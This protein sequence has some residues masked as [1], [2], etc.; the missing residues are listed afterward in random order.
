MT[1]AVANIDKNDFAAMAALMGVATPA[2]GKKS[3]LAR[4]RLNHKAIMGTAEIKGKTKK[5]E[6]VPA[7]T[8]RIDLDDGSQLYAESA[9]FRP[10]MSRFMHKRFVKGMGDKPNKFIKTLMGTNINVDL[11]DTEGTSNCGRPSGFIKDW[12]AVPKATQD[13]IKATKRTRVMLGTVTFTDAVTAAGKDATVV[14]VPVI[15]EVDNRDAFKMYDNQYK[16]LE[17]KGLLPVYY[18]FALTAEEKPL[19]NGDS[20]YLPVCAV[21]ITA[22]MVEVSAEDMETLTGFNDWVENYNAYVT[23]AWSSKHQEPVDEADAE[24]IDMFIAED[25]DV[26]VED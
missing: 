14:D 15:Y 1:N 10:F 17:K 4:L 9:T 18:P 25:D 26:E 2:K 21:D 8:Y 6:V 13:L 23:D 7:G 12:A 19:P 24:I 11:K 5:V 16:A 20:F 22:D 3:N